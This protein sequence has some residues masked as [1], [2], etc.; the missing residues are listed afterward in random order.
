MHPSNK[1]NSTVEIHVRH[2][3]DLEMLQNT[4]SDAPVNHNQ[5]FNWAKHLN[6]FPLF[7]TSQLLVMNNALQNF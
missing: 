1:G 4:D 5:T 2:P 7:K 3:C 6:L